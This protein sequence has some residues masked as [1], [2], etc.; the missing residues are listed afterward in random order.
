[1]C[2]FLEIGA[3]NEPM[4][5]ADVDRLK[6]LI[7]ACLIC[8]RFGRSGRRARASMPR[9]DRVFNFEVALD[10]FYMHGMAA[11]SMVDGGIDFPTAVFVDDKRAVTLWNA[12][13]RNWVL[14]FAGAPTRIYVDREL[15]LAG[16]YF[17]TKSEDLVSNF[18]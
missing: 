1:M 4:K 9:A 11:L 13:F 2:R 8:E 17:A 10:V 12:F 6:N 18:M 7:D 14:R 16:S 15:C 3:P 5:A